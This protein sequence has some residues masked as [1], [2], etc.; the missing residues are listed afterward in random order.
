MAD[1]AKLKA[2]LDAIASQL[3][4]LSSAQ[5]ATAEQYQQRLTEWEVKYNSMLEKYEAE[6]ERV[7]NAAA[8]I[9]TII[10]PDIRST[11]RD[12]PPAPVAPDP[13]SP[14]TSGHQPLHSEAAPPNEKFKDYGHLEPTT[15]K[16]IALSEGKNEPTM[17]MDSPASRPA[18]LQVSKSWAIL[19]VEAAA[20]NA[21]AE[22]TVETSR[23]PD[24]IER[25][26]VNVHMDH[27]TNTESSNSVLEESVGGKSML[28]TAI[29]LKLEATM[30]E[31]S[32]RGIELE[33]SQQELVAERA[34]RKKT[35]SRVEE[36]L[37]FLVRPLIRYMH[38]YTHILYFLRF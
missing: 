22:R 8:A 27:D 6:L 9:Q 21:A 2:D 30:K 38:T 15:T 7:K 25:E 12:N 23:T 32:L 20:L 28:S 31:L 37:A 5:A 33:A 17:A 16:D 35:Q 34:E 1:N 10:A 24:S 19:T 36:L 11:R 18:A 13:I 26:Y 29:Q 4:D 3:N 14:G